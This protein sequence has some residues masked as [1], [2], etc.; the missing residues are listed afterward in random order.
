MF[1]A[2]GPMI[3][4]QALT[5]SV[6]EDHRAGPELLQPIVDAGPRSSYASSVVSRKLPRDAPGWRTALARST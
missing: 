2:P 1:T 3:I 5:K 6:V 4:L